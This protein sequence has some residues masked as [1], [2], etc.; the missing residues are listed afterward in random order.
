MAKTLR[1]EILKKPWERRGAPAADDN[2]KVDAGILPE[3]PGCFRPIAS[4]WEVAVRLV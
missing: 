4:D 3:Q 1:A 2:H